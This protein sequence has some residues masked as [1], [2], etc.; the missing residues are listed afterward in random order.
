ML[1]HKLW[2]FDRPVAIGCRRDNGF[3]PVA[4][5]LALNDI[6][7]PVTILEKHHRNDGDR[8]QKG[9]GKKG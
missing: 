1:G 3:G 7:D 9:E 8:A 2:R 4:I 6:R 5:Q